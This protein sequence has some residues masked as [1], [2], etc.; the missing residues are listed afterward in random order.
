MIIAKNFRNAFLEILV[1]FQHYLSVVFVLCIENCHFLFSPFICA[2]NTI[3]ILRCCLKEFTCHIQ[4]SH[5]ILFDESGIQLKLLN[6]FL[7]FHLPFF[8]FQN[9]KQT[10][11]ANDFDKGILI[12]SVHQNRQFGMKWN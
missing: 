5:S 4:H 1:D 8:L 6:C 11:P 10:S 12:Y 7:L 9:K 2:G 3:Q